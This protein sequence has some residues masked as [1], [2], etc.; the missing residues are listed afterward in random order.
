M[1]AAVESIW[2]EKTPDLE[3]GIVPNSA[4]IEAAEM[5]IRL[6]G[7]PRVKVCRNGRFEDS[8]ARTLGMTVAQGKWTR[9]RRH[10]AAAKAGDP[11]RRRERGEHKDRD[12]Q[13]RAMPATET[14]DA[15][16]I[17]LIVQ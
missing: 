9:R 3:A 4:T 6:G 7:D 12:L 11:V 14:L 17:C 2:A 16:R 8:A 15:P 10:L 1:R 13:F 5:A